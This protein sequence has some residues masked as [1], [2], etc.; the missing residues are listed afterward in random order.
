VKILLVHN[1]YLKSGGEDV[2]FRAETELL[3]RYGHDVQTYEDHNTRIAS[4]NPAST[5]LGTIWSESSRQRLITSL[6]AEKSDIVHF[7]NTFPLISP[8]AYYAC[9]EK[10]AAVVQTLQN[11]RLLCPVATFYRNGRICEECLQ[12]KI[13]W[14][15]IIHACY[16]HSYA[17]SAVVSAML[18]VHHVLGTWQNKVD[19]YI[20]LTEF[21]H[22]KF[23][24]GGL[25][26]T[27]TFLKP[28]TLSSDPGCK[29]GTGD[30]ALFIGRL[31]EEKGV[32]TLLNAWKLLSIPLKVAGDGPLHLELLQSLK[33]PD[34]E[35]VTYV[36]ALPHAEVISLMKNARILI[37][38]SEW[39]EGF[40][41]TIAEAFACGLPILASRLGAMAEII[42]DGET[43]M[44]FPPGHY[45][46]LA[47]KVLQLWNDPKELARIGRNARQEYE[48]KYTPEHN[49][50]SLMN[51]YRF[52]LENKR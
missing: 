28:N 40:P 24:E 46:E 39:Y 20:T 5:A 11:F 43:G 30:F 21:A 41:L 16:R 35:S 44:L 10:G 29:E 23:I 31:S 27:K 47:E 7:Q 48:Q 17:Q 13:T 38:P 37:F 26:A 14:P 52:A 4:L 19:A 49:Y 18:A 15:G 45:Q 1:Y 3:R 50:Q 8:A 2:A 51:I 32:R 6:E 33:S 42:H 36:G 12:K 34:L 22:A 25:P 9:H